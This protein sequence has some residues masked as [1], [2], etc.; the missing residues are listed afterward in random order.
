MIRNI[1]SAFLLLWAGSSAAVAA[2]WKPNESTV[3]YAIQGTDAPSLYQSIGKN[4]PELKGLRRA[5]AHTTWDLKWRRNYQ[6]QA[7][8]CV[9][10]SALPFLTITY[11]LPKPAN[12]LSGNTAAKW[13]TFYNG[14]NAHELIHGD[15]IRKM[16]QNII[17]D[18]V[19]LSTQTDN[20]N[21]DQ[22][23]A[24]V[25]EKVA[26]RFGEYQNWSNGFDREEMS[27]GGNVHQLVL[28]FL[29]R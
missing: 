29:N 8:G 19:G 25:L 16:T 14:I 2:E 22:L 15:L 23:R 3:H 9:L 6:P 28:N 21:C 5:M 7:Q 20:A 24:D 18:T 17:N 12:T 4:G 27:S 26:A 13:N 11:T 10:K 1:A